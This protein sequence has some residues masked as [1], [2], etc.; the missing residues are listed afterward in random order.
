MLMETADFGPNPGNL[1][2]FSHVPAAAPKTSNGMPLLVELHGCTQTASGYDTGAGWSAL[3][4]RQGF[5]VLAPEQKMVNN[6]NTCFDWFQP[7]DT[8]RGEGE[9]ASIAAMIA[10]L[11]AAHPID[12]SQVFI[13]GLSAG[14]AMT[15]VMLAT[16]PELFAGGAIIAGLPY[17]SARNV[18]E[19]LTVMRHAPLRSPYDWGALVQAASAHA[20]PWPRIAIWH[21]D[22]DTTVHISNAEAGM[23]Q[24]ASVHGVALGEAQEEK[25]QGHV[26]LR[27]QVKGR[28]VLELHTI[29]GLGHGTPIAPAQDGIGVP[30]PFILEAQISSTLEIAK[31]FGL[32]DDAPARPNVR[33]AP[34]TIVQNPRHIQAVLTGTAGIEGVIRR[35][36]KAAR[37]LKD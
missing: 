25:T 8:R 32:V 3:G 11:I 27:W 36:L 12:P 28:T 9:A 35:A 22:A 21:G 24:W 29:A 31:F 4:E 10:Q 16:Y 2:M 26:R 6:P 34:Q 17:G 18:P 33:P 1:R 30:A 37:L 19:A 7:G 20:G 15:A 13:T 5:A 14:G 23:A